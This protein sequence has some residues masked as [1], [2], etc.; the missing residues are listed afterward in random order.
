MAEDILNTS[1]KKEVLPPKKCI[2]KKLPIH[3]SLQSEDYS[4]LSIYGT[5][6]DH[7]AELTNKN[8]ELNKILIS[9]FNFTEA[10]VVWSIRFEMARTIEDVLARRLRILFLNARLA[11]EAAPRTGELLK[12]ELRKD[13][14]WLQ[15]QLEDYYELAKK[16]LYKSS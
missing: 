4:S 14:H 7:I 16:Y 6:A 2:T 12:Q 15:L 11:M 13:D 9:G 1:I 3:G 10:E 5:D 8:P